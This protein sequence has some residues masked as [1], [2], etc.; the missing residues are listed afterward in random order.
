MASKYGRYAKNNTV[1]GGEN[2][3]PS[4]EQI[5]NDPK[6]LK[7]LGD[8]SKAL[9]DNSYD[10]DE[11]MGQLEPLLNFFEGWENIYPQPTTSDLTSTMRRNGRDE[12][13]IA[14]AISLQDKLYDILQEAHQLPRDNLLQILRTNDEYEKTYDE[15]IELYGETVNY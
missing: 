9:L 2:Y 3:N 1:N 13:E 10:E 14:H 12:Q 4:F 8:D 11:L 15:L 7:T 5:K 6:L